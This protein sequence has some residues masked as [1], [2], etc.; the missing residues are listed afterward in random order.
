MSLVCS[1]TLV[2]LLKAL[3][4][5]R[6]TLTLA[7]LSGIKGAPTVQP[8]TTNAQD[9][10]D[11]Y[12]SLTESD[13]TS[14]SIVNSIGPYFLSVAFLSLLSRNR[15]I[16]PPSIINTVSMNGWTKDPSTSG[17]AF[18]YLSSKA[19]I[20]QLTSQ[21]AHDF[22]P[23]NIRVNAIAPGYFITSMGPGTKVDEYG[24]CSTDSTDSWELFGFHT[25]A[26]KGAGGVKDVGSVALMLVTN[27]F[28]N[29]ETVLVDGGT[30]LMH[31][32]SY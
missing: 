27:E 20:G 32:S 8:T 11:A 18:P 30:L 3:R 15:S 7:R 4:T 26:R 5:R 29:G 6:P 9:Y 23:L 21:L 25:P 12:F 24:I 2:S 31:P 14:V 28:V 16:H 22:L 1:T 17:R 19:S 10:H 13:F